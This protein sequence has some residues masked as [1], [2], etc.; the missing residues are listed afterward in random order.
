LAIDIYFYRLRW[1]QLRAAAQSIAF[2][3]RSAEFSKRRKE[4]RSS[5]QRYWNFQ[6]GTYDA[7]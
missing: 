6:S 2:N 1:N 4:P 7:D 3:R 5:V